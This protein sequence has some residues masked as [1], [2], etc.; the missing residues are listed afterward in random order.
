MTP[1]STGKGRGNLEIDLVLKHFG[2]FRMSSGT[3]DTDEFYARRRLVRKLDRDERTSTLRALKSGD[4]TFEELRSNEGRSK[5]LTASAIKLQRNLW[6][7]FERV[8]PTMGG[9]NGKA[10]RERYAKS[11]R[12][13][14]RKGAQW[15]PD[16]ATVRDLARVPWKEL[17][18]VWNASGTDW[19]HM[20]RAVGAFLTAYLHVRHAF[21]ARVM[22][23]QNF[24]TAKARKRKPNITAEIFLSIVN[25]EKVP[26]TARRSYWSIAIAGLRINEYLPLDRDRHLVPMM[27]MVQVPGT[28]TEGSERE[29][30]VCKRLWDRFL[31]GVPS[32]YAEDRLRR[33]WHKACLD[34]GLAR[35][36]PD[37]RRKPKLDRASGKMI[38]AMMYEGPHLHD[39]RHCHGQ[40]A[41]DAGVEESKVQGSYGHESPGMT[42]DY[43]VRAATEEVSEGVADILIAAEKT[44]AKLALRKGRKQA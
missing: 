42:R 14:Q 31:A 33:Y 9:E 23:K 3:K 21:R 8:L 10:T 22:R 5:K 44:R 19:M 32:H 6:D 15:L 35:M 18:P 28:K 13:L 37:P 7:E 20:R 17:K 11:I 36:V 27:R 29:I 34:L 26:L 24:P 4:I 40:W 2:E 1:S 30:I 41:V 38:P 39:L 16:S 12:A 43:T 25:Y